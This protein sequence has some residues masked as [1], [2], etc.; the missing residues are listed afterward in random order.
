MMTYLTDVW[1]LTITHAAAIVNVFTGVAAIMPIGMGFLVDTF[2]GDKW[3]LLL[4]SIAYSIVGFQN[5]PHFLCISTFF[6]HT[7]NIGIFFGLFKFALIIFISSNITVIQAKHNRMKIKEQH[8][9][10]HLKKITPRLLTH[11]LYWL[12]NVKLHEY[13]FL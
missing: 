8:W 5:F 2:M 6:Y 1:S 10:S 12:R 13:L 4:A 7:T 11:G 9:A 3:M